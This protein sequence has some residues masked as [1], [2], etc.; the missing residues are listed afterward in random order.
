MCLQT[1]SPRRFGLKGLG[2]KRWEMAQTMS[3]PCGAFRLFPTPGVWE[4]PTAQGD[5]S[6][7]CV[8]VCCCCCCVF[9]LLVLGLLLLFGVGGVCVCWFAPVGVW[10]VVVV[11]VCRW[12][13]CVFW[14]APGAHP[15]RG[16]DG[17]LP[18]PLVCRA[19]QRRCISAAAW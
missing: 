18:L 17:S 9:L 11:F 10:L 12:R 19:D 6:V 14:F 1:P 2:R 13:S 3:T 16:A 8:C 15:P 5:V 4:G 7:A